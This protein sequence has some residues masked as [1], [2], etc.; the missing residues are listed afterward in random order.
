MLHKQLARCHITSV[1]S[2]ARILPDASSI[3]HDGCTPSELGYRHTL[4]AAGS[5]KGFRNSRKSAD[6]ARALGESETQPRSPSACADGTAALCDGTDRMDSQS[7]PPP[8]NHHLGCFN[9]PPRSGLNTVARGPTELQSD[10][11]EALCESLGL[12]GIEDSKPSS[13]NPEPSRAADAVKQETCIFSKRPRHVSPAEW[14]IHLVSLPDE[15]AEPRKRARECE[16][17][18]P[19]DVDAQAEFIPTDP[20]LRKRS[21]AGVPAPC[22]DWEPVRYAPHWSTRVHLKAG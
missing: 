5:K 3:Y 15:P 19:M 18:T 16:E 1:S 22:M 21:R 6:N 20:R 12:G 13:C 8:P 11:F 10:A 7:T 4:R 9:S 14:L 2:Q 17:L